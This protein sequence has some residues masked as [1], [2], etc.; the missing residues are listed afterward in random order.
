MAKR[1]DHFHI[2]KVNL[3]KIAVHL[4]PLVE[5]E[6]LVADLVSERKL[7]VADGGSME[8]KLRVN[9]AE[10]G[11]DDGGLCRRNQTD[12]VLCDFV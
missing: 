5:Q 10:I 7:V 1:V 9:L 12:N 4:P 11:G 8:Q 2:T 3:E 6:P